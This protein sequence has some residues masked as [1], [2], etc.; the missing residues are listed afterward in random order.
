MTP[1]AQRRIY[2]TNVS[3]T[4][5]YRLEAKLTFARRVTPTGNTT[6]SAFHGESSTASTGTFV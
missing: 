6:A 5:S 2:Q 4:P 3:T 1:E